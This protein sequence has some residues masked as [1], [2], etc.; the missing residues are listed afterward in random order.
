MPREAPVTSTARLTSND[1]AQQRP[2]RRPLLVAERGQELVADALLG[3][4]GALERVPALLGEVDY[5]AAA[6]GGIAPALDVA[7]LLHLVEKQHAVVRVEP[8]R[9]AQLLLEGGG[10]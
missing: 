1:A 5:V 6:V 8:Q 7:Q 4:L 3:A 9:L 2:E 10:A